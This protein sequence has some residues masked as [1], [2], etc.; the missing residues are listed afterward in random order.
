[1]MIR[2]YRDA[3]LGQRDRSYT[4]SLMLGL[5]GQL[6]AAARPF[7]PIMGEDTNGVI[8]NDG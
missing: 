8:Y 1:M 3:L 2:T 7:H 6:S 4:Q 5:G